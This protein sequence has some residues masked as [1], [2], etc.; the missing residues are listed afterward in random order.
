[1][2][3][4]VGGGLSGWPAA[5]VSGGMGAPPLPE[6]VNPR[7]RLSEG[8]WKGLEALPLSAEL[9]RKMR[10]PP[11]LEG[12]LVDEVTLNAAAAGL[13]AGDVIVAVNG[14]PVKTLEEFL[15]ESRRVQLEKRA[16]IMVFRAGRLQTYLLQGKNNLG[17]AQVET[18]PMILPGEIMPHPYRGPCTSCH[19]IGSTGHIVPDP[20]GI[21]LPPPP[22]RAGVA[23]PHQDRGPCQACH[24]ITN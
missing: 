11:E 3:A 18:A 15:A 20:D 4:S 22:I 21:V 16:S 7:V 8:H 12:L 14:R 6:F 13:L 24:V 9:K 1:M 10:L 2:G 19:A 17:Y 23:C 5:G